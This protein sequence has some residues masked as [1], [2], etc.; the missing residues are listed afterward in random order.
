MSPLDHHKKQAKQYLRWHREGYFPVATLIRESLPRFHG[1]PDHDILRATFRLC[2]AQEMVARKLGQENWVALAKGAS[3]MHPRSEKPRTVITSAEPQLFVT[4][5]DVSLAFYTQK[6]GFG[7]RFS[8]GDPAFYAQVARDAGGLNLRSV[9]GPV[10]A[11]GF[12]EREGDFLCTTLTLEAATPLSLEYQDA[13]VFF[14]KG[15]EL[16]LGVHAPSSSA[17]QMATCW[18]SLVDRQ[19][20]ATA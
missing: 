20:R 15:C 6:L 19:R 13:G 10:F 8:Y 12:R 14:I 5:M 2:D 7:V 3:D 4:D 11:T 1:I 18:L 16:S 17:I 9:D